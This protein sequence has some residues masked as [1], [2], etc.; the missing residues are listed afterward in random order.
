MGKIIKNHH[1]E[2]TPP[3]RNDE[4]CW[5]LPTLG[6]YHPQ[7]PGQLRV[8]FDSSAQFSNISFNDVLLTGPDLNN[9]F[10]G[11]LIRFR[12]EQVAVMA[13]AQQMFQFPG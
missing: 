7:K 3:L 6:V 1:A 12:K 11:V 2:V 4:E 13:D 9:S 8:V 10:V 5:Y